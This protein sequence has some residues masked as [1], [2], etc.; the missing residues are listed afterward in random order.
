MEK[1]FFADLH[2]FMVL[3]E[4]KR[5]ISL[6]LPRNVLKYFFDRGFLLITCH[7]VD[8]KQEIPKGAMA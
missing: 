7:P 6:S 2:R 1:Y 3:D 5:E 8:Y 4:I